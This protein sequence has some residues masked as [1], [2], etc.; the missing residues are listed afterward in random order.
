M[1]N[2]ANS[3]RLA[4]QM[5]RGGKGARR[6]IEDVLLLQGWK[7]GEASAMILGLHSRVL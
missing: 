5:S 6:R 3:S 2:Q 7:G 1:L 4:D